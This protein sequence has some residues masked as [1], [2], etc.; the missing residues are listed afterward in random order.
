MFFVLVERLVAR[1]PTCLQLSQST[2]EFWIFGEDGVFVM[3]LRWS[4]DTI[5]DL[6]EDIW[7]LAGLGQDERLEDTFSMSKARILQA[8]YPRYRS[9]HW[10]ENMFCGGFLAAK[11]FMNNLS[12]EE[13]LLA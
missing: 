1:L 10:S 12:L 3:P 6:T 11:Y 8:T 13:L 7:Y 5:L 2:P 9:H 4:N